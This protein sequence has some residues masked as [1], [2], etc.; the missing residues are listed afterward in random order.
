[1]RLLV[2]RP[3]EDADALAQALRQIGA[4]AVLAPVMTIEPEAGVSVD[5][6]GIQALLFTSANGVRAFADQ[7]GVRNLPVLAVGDATARAAAQA[8]FADIESADGDTDD[9]AALAARQLDAKA[10]ALLHPAGHDVAGPLKQDLEARG[11]E[12]RRQT[13]YR[14]QFIRTL[15]EDA[16]RAIVGRELDGVLFFSPRTAQSFV[17]L[18]TSA[19]LPGALG[20]LYAYCLSA[21]VAEIARGVQWKDVRIAAEPT[22]AA[23]LERI[24]ADMRAEAR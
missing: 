13:F 4:A 16:R 2:T 11:F 19:G 22:Q 21:A 20:N 14:A 18:V 6:G 5:L 12:V 7:S 15:P 8:G 23:L 17:T 3:R 1:M 24:A 9:L 10:G